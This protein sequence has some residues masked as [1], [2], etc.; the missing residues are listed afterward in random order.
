MP[1]AYLYL[2]KRFLPTPST[3]RA[4]AQLDQGGLPIPIS[5]HALHEEGDTRAASTLHGTLY[6]YPRPPRGGRQLEGH[7]APGG[8]PIST[9]AL[10]EEGD[11]GPG[12]L[13]GQVRQISTHALHEEGDSQHQSFSSGWV[14]FYPRP[15]RGGRPGLACCF[16]Q[17]F[18]FLPTP[19]T[20]RATFER[21][22]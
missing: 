13:L 7:Q 10:H 5:T 15:P 16:P 4:T 22:W 1:G 8:V 20:R 3:R 14:N 11:G 12:P 6:F 17:S 2:E 18:E 21:V 9:H 19:S